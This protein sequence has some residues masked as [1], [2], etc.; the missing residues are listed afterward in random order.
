MKTNK[1]PIALQ[2]YSVQQE[3]TNDLRG[4]LAQLKE[5]GYDGVELAGL[6]GHTP[7]QLRKILDEVGLELVSAHVPVAD[8]LQDAMLDGYASMGLAYVAIPWM[9]VKADAACVA[10]CIDTIRTIALRAKE[11]GLQLLYHNHDFEFA[12]VDGAYILDTYYRSLSPELLQTEVDTCWVKVAG[13][14]PAD[15]LRSYAGRSPIVHLK[16]FVG[17]KTDNMYALIGSHSAKEE[18]TQAFDFRP[19]GYGVQDIPRLVATA[20]EIGAKWLVVEQDRAAL[21][22]SSMECARLSIDYLKAL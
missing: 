16:D 13:E 22:K 21:G 12:K 2:L 8:L 9:E 10:A 20:R 11:R 14:D 4:T 5:M 19:V 18:A 6:Y 3:A 1:L 17:R 15:Y 7:A